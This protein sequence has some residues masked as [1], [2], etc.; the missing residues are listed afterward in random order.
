MQTLPTEEEV[1]AKLSAILDPLPLE[2]QAKAL[3]NVLEKLNAWKAEVSGHLRYYMH[4]NHTFTPLPHEDGEALELVSKFIEP[5]EN[6]STYGMLCTTVY[7][8]GGAWTNGTDHLH[9]SGEA[10]IAF[11]PK[12]GEWLKRNPASIPSAIDVHAPKQ[13]K[14]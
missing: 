9:H 11:E 7:R 10:W 6:K 8:R 1:M 5:G 14:R 3:Q 2:R 12:V 4:D 13:V